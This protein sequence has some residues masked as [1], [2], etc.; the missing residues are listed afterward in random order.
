M[1]NN[2]IKIITT[3]TILLLVSGQI[4]AAEKTVKCPIESNDK[5]VYQGQC[6]YFSEK[7]AEAISISLSNPQSKDKPLYDTILMVSVYIGKGIAEV[8]GLTADG[9]N[10]RWGIAK[11]SQ[12]SKHCWQG[13]DFRVCVW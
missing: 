9:I 1:M 8:S 7:T 11:K 10:S 4:M 12:K 13:E 2:Y 6:R 5:V 3:I